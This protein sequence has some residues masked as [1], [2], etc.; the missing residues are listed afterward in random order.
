MTRHPHLV[1]RWYNG[2]TSLKHY[3]FPR[4]QLFSQGL[5]AVAGK[6][7]RSPNMGMVQ[8][9]KIEHWNCSTSFSSTL[10]RKK[11]DAATSKYRCHPIA[12]YVSVGAFSQ[13]HAFVGNILRRASHSTSPKTMMA[14]SPAS[15]AWNISVIQLA[16]SNL[17]LPIFPS[18]NEQWK[19][20]LVVQG[21]YGILLP[22]LCGD[23]KKLLYI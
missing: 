22:H 19:E 3:L 2:M 13:P 16:E 7:L 1:Q 11:R 5:Q 10:S 4:N 6:A 8:I 17:Y 12:P 21:I 14:M 23:C 9:A 18:S 15:H 20:T